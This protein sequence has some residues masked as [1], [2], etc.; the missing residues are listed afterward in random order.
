MFLFFCF[1]DVR[2]GRELTR[3]Q[4]V[5]P[6]SMRAFISK[7]DIPADAKDRLMK[8]T[9]ETYVGYAEQLAKGLKV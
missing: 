2:G 5:G 9:P 3:G 7:L 1:G 4:R 8:L 6:E